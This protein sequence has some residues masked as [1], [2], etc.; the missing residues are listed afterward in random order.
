MYDETPM[1]MTLFRAMFE[2][3]YLADSAAREAAIRAELVARVRDAIS[4]VAVDRTTAVID[5]QA[6]AAVDALAD[7]YRAQLHLT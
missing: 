6:E 7:Y 2:R 5:R 1:D 4:A 3:Q